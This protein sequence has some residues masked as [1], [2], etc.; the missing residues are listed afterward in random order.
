MGSNIREQLFL[1]VE[2]WNFRG[3]AAKPPSRIGEGPGFSYGLNW[4]LAAK[5]VLVKDK[6][7]RNLESSELQQRGATVA[8]SLSGLPVHVRGSVTGGTSELSKAQ[9]GK[10]LKQV[11]NHL[12]SI[13]NIFVHDGAIGSSSNCDAKVRVISDS[14]AAVLSLSNVLWKTPTR[15]VSHDSSPLTVYVATSISPGVAETVGL[16]SQG[17]KGFIAAD[18]ERSSLILCGKAFLD[19]NSIKEALSALSGLIICSRGGLPL[20]ARLLEYGDSV[21]LLF[22][23]DEAIQSCSDSFV[24]ADAGVILSAE[25][26]APYFQSPKSGGSNLFKLPAA[27]VLA[28]SDRMQVKPANYPAVV[29]LPLCHYDDT[30]NAKAS[31]RQLKEAI[32]S[33]L[34][35][36]NVPAVCAINQATLALY[37]ARRTS[38]I[39]VNIGF[40]V[41]SVVPILNGKVMRKVGVEVV[42]LGALKLTGFLKELMQR[43]NINFASM[44]TI[45]TLKEALCYVAADYEAELSKDTEALLEVEGEGWFTLSKERFQ[46]GEILFQPRIAGVRAMGLQQAVALCMHHCHDAE[47][48]SD[49]AWFKTV[50]LSGGT[51]CLPGLP[52][53]L[54]KELHGLLPPLIS[55]GI[56]IIPPPYGALTVW[57]GAKVISNLSNFPGPWCMTKKQCRQKSRLN[58]IW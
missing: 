16:G 32:Y 22:A 31:R 54:E 15:A 25:G 30:E 7:F 52:E 51:A 1:L 49:D 11:T 28:S 14:P 6:A 17:N 48:T 18:I 5:G 4:A 44:Y 38:G 40:H 21:L 34:F 27:V 19:A 20:S 53:R 50:V 55:H 24:S 10:L 29:S 57:Y 43:N 47:L 9:F 36:M 45:R 37:A 8:E 58:L 33:A 39:V 23:P 35:D 41:T 12:S 13:S 46:T 42:G 2:Q 3:L 26:V 56:R